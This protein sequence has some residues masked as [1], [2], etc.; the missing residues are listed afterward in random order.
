MLSI[1]KNG[2][3]DIYGRL[4]ICVYAYISLKVLVR[5][6]FW[7]MAYSFSENWKLIR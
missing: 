7:L 1:V 2:K 5:S 6:L 4:F 3:V